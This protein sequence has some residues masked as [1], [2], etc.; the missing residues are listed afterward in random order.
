MWL[1][2]EVKTFLVL[3]TISKDL[4]DILI[5]SNEFN[6]FLWELFLYLLRVDEEVLE[7]RPGSLHF[8]DD[9]SDF[10][11]LGQGFLPEVD[12]LFESRKISGGEHGCDRNL[13]L[14]KHVKV[15]F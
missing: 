9:H 3:E 12:L 10:T 4:L 7:E 15:L 1:D 2:T 6:G 14:F 8:T 5:D 13:V 11:D